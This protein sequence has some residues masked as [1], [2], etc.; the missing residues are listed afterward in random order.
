MDVLTEYR[1]AWAFLRDRAPEYDEE[2]QIA[3]LVELGRQRPLVVG[4]DFRPDNVSGI[5]AALPGVRGI[6]LTLADGVR[7]EDVHVHSYAEA[8]RVVRAVGR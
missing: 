4:L 6:A 2:F 7:R 8:L 3:D 1:D 5:V